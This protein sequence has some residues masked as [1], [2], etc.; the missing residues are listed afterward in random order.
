MNPPDE[1]MTQAFLPAMRQL[2]AARLRSQGLSQSKISG[3]L[4][5]TQ[6]SVSL[7]LSSNPVKAYSALSRFAM[8]REDADARAALLADSVKAG[9]AEGVGALHS[10]WVGILGSGSACGYHR[11]LYPS[12][13]DCDVCVKEFGG[14]GGARTELISGVSEAVRMIEGSPEFVNVMPEVSVNIAFAAANASSPADVVAIPGR[15]VRV[16][17]RAKAMLPPE[18]GVSA[19]MSKVLLM[20][21]ERRKGLRACMNL[22]YDRRMAEVMRK[23][24]LRTITIGEYS[25]HGAEDATAEALRR[26]LASSSEPFDAVIDAGASGIEPNV[27]VFARGAHEVAE[28]ALDLARAYSAA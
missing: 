23:R 25:R 1:M 22:R 26:R 15:I 7:Y 19:H 5:T 28:L 27:Y 8:S 14:R 6:A 13:A 2:V 21:K 11:D 3:L 9:S 4:G 18:A 12:L 17:D 24:H 10:I 16:K 20:V